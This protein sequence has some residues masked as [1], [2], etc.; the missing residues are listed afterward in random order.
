MGDERVRV[1]DLTGGFNKY[2]HLFGFGGRKAQEKG[3]EEVED[4][5]F[6]ERLKIKIVK[7][8][9]GEI[10]ENVN[11]RNDGKQLLT[12]A[13]NVWANI[14][15]DKSLILDTFVCISLLLVSI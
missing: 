1:L 14:G 7:E 4:N 3:G 5:I 13:H 11:V 2:Q 6:P 10:G 9:T 15:F 12:R 8:K